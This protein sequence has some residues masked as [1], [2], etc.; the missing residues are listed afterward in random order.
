MSR[1][2]CVLMS[3]PMLLSVTKLA[4]QMLSSWHGAPNNILL[5]AGQSR[6]LRPLYSWIAGQE[7]VFRV[8]SHLSWRPSLP[9]RNR[10]ARNFA[11]R[12]DRQ[13][14]IN[15]HCQVGVQTS[16]LDVDL[17]HGAWY[18]T[19]PCRCD[20]GLLISKQDLVRHGSGPRQMRIQPGVKQMRSSA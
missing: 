11:E 2:Q 15:V 16:M 18:L 9:D 10:N 5:G 6:S 19:W 8:V 17:G 20:E 12:E 7:V 14:S 1:A 3:L 4:W 13:T